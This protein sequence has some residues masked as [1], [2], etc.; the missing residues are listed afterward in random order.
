MNHTLHHAH[1]LDLA[2]GYHGEHC[3]F[4]FRP[5]TERTGDDFRSWCDLYADI[6]ANGIRNPLVCYGNRVLIG[7]RR[8]EI[9]VLLGLDDVVVCE[10]ADDVGQ[11]HLSDVRK[12]KDWLRSSGIYT[13]EPA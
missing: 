10:L 13:E 5:H 9:A 7:M 2:P 6:A 4:H 8:W 12:L 3:D 11:Y 1:P